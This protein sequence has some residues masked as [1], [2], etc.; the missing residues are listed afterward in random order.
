MAVTNSFLENPLEL[1]HVNMNSDSKNLNPWGRKVWKSYTG[2]AFYR[3]MSVAVK[4]FNEGVS[5]AEVEHE[6]NETLFPLLIM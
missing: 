5:Q 3:E 1:I 4:Q 6:A 2:L